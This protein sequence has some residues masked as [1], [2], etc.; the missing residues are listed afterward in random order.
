MGTD[1]HPAVE[2]RR[3]GIWR[4][5][6]PKTECPYYYDYKFE[7]GQRV[8][9]LDADGNRIRSKWDRCAT[10]LPEAFEMMAYDFGGDLI[11]EGVISEQQFLECLIKSEPPTSWSGG[12]SGPNIVTV[13][14]EE[15]LA[16]FGKEE[17]FWQKEPAKPK[18]Y[19]IQY[20]WAV[21]LNTA[22]PDIPEII[23]YMHALI[24]KGGTPEDV[25][26]VMD[27]DS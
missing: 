25:R 13:T 5:H 22:C 18:T 16:L 15:Y 14:P 17:A 20:R 21:P 23:T 10:R 26:L 8:Y 4:Y 1:I 9:E 7:N 2:V 12:I 19:H 11:E 3:K 24:P 27:F 6:R